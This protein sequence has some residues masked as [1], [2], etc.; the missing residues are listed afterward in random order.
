M[1]HKRLG[2]EE[3]LSAD[4]KIIGPAVDAAGIP[5]GFMPMIKGTSPSIYQ[6]ALEVLSV[7][8]EADKGKPSHPTLKMTAALMTAVIER[9]DS[10]SMIAFGI[11][12]LG[13]MTEKGPEAFAERLGRFHQ[14]YTTLMGVKAIGGEE[15]LQAA[16]H[17][18]RLKDLRT[19][20][21]Q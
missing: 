18:L 1:A 9:N 15:A 19:L 12:A 6:E 16:L 10:K 3:V 5:A 20:G 7:A 11:V 2:G 17:P 13:E 14:R 21:Q 4:E 8:I